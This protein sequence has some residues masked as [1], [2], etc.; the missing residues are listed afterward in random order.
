VAADK[1]KKP[2][3]IF[4]YTDIFGF[5]EI[6][7][8]RVLHASNVSYLND[9]KELIY[10]DSFVRTGTKKR[11]EEVFEEL[12]RDG[13]VNKPFDSETLAG[14][15]ADNLLRSIH[16]VTARFSPIFVC[17]FCRG[18]DEFVERNGLLSQ[19]RGY[20][21]EGGVAIAFSVKGLSDLV[22][23]EAASFACAP[24]FLGDVI[25]GKDDPEFPS[26]LESFAEF[27]KGV[28]DIIESGLAS[29]GIKYQVKGERVELEKLY[30]PYSKIA[31]RL[32]HPGFAEERE[33]RMIV[34]VSRGLYTNEK[35]ATKVVKFKKR[36]NYLLPYIEVAALEKA[37]L[38][39]DYVI[40]GP[41]REA[42]RRRESVEFVLR[43][44]GYDVPVSLSEIPFA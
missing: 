32:K 30:E 4:H 11:F 25:Y 22:E 3:R 2:Q 12:R 31:P 1:T 17:C 38:P 36:D 44:Y 18:D 15:E 43:E 9:R 21:S 26:L 6:L 16:R 29:Q 13:I 41:S 27:P 20:G 42:E 23:R 24:C 39:I 35:R 5:K 34:P 14:Y 10:A 19:W 37:K 33:Y 40:V 28:P 7:A 8:S